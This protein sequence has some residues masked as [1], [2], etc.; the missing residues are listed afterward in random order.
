MCSN[1]LVRKNVIGTQSTCSEAARGGHLDVLKW[2]RQAG[3]EWDADTCS[4]AARGGHLDVL[5]WARQAGCEW[6]ADTC[7]DA[8][9]GGHLDVLKYTTQSLYYCTKPLSVVRILRIA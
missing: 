9:R 7:S 5:K 8:A 3:C 2:A 6:D 1:G 4:E